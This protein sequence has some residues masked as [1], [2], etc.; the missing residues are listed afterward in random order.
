MNKLSVQMVKGCASVVLNSSTASIID[1]IGVTEAEWE[2]VVGDR[3][4]IGQDRARVTRILDSLLYGLVDT[5]GLPRFELPAEYV[6]TVISLF[7]SPC[8]YFSACSWMGS[9]VPGGILSDSRSSDIPVEGLER[10][11][12]SQI[13]ALVCDI[14]SGSFLTP[15]AH[16][17]EKKVNLKLA[18]LTEGV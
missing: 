11:R 9:Y 3:S 12:P 1:S 10:V 5:M 17:F 13:F 7:V 8:N 14:R 16:T 2:L 15:M 18:L 4:W 6:A